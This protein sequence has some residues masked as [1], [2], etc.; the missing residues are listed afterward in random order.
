LN[1]ATAFVAL[2]GTIAS[3][4]LNGVV[5]RDLVKEPE[6]DCATLGSAFALQ[7]AGG[8]L[9]F[10][11]AVIVI[12]YVRPTDA[13]AKL[14]V[15][16]IGFGMVLRATDTVKYWFESQVD[17][18]YVIWVENSVFLIFSC[19]KV[20]LILNHASLMAFVWAVL[21]EAT[22]VAIALLSMYGWRRGDLRKWEIRIDRAK[23]LLKDSWPLILSGLSVM[24]Y[25]RIDQIMLGQMVNDNAVGIYSAALRISEVFYAIPMIVVASLF[26]AIIDAKKKGEDFYRKRVQKLLDLMALLSLLIAL[27]VSL[28]SDPIIRLLYGHMYTGA[29]SVLQIHVW[30]SLFVFVGVAGGKWYLMEN[31]QHL[32][33]YRTAAGA[34]LN[35]VLNLFLIPRYGIY[36]AA[37]ATVLSQAMAAYL[38]DGSLKRTRWLFVAKTKA[39]FLWPLSWL[40]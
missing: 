31:L 28:F 10:G 13:L 24:I 12:G 3:L 16:V 33:L 14:M 34:V 5:V 18:K 21:A 11:M 40:R 19:V 17:S 27:S 8:L 23:A 36:G 38:L 4:G 7:L 9:A 20:A 32:I 39:I 2:F 15:G 30:A 22:I 35:I 26:P 6:S 25:M 29:G 37:I 1:Y